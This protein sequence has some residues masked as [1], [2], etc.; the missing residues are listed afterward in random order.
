MNF[1]FYLYFEI[2]STFNKIKNKQNGHSTSAQLL[3]KKQIGP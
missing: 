2:Q 3:A 1:F